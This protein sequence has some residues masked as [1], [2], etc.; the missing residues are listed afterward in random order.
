MG[1]DASRTTM[2]SSCISISK[3]TIA[4]AS[5]MNVFT[6]RSARLCSSAPFSAPTNDNNDKNSGHDLQRK[7][8]GRL[9][10]HQ[11]PAPPGGMAKQQQQQQQ[12]Q[13]RKRTRRRT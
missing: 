6:R 10:E 9:G 8:P 4:S 11:T 5:P 3:S 2:L 12:Q 1:N 13:P 7:R